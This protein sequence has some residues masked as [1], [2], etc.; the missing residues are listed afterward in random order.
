MQMN[1]PKCVGKLEHKIIENVE[2]DVCFVCEGIWFDAGELEKVIQADS[3]DLQFIDL[4]REELDGKKIAGL[5]DELDKKEA[6]CPRCGNGIKLVRKEHKG[7]HKVNVDI[8]QKCNG[9]W[10]DGGEIN[11]LR[12]RGLVNLKDKIDDNASFLKYI[13]SIDG[14]KKF[15][16]LAFHKGSANQR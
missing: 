2:V 5:R 8:C 11:E 6:I 1:C 16:Q 3:K 14:F 7:K 15:I 13:F 12:R 10:L 4:D 9:I